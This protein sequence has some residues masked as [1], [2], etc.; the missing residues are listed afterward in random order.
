MMGLLRVTLQQRHVPI[1]NQ[2][3]LVARALFES[4]GPVSAEDIVSSLR[5]RGQH[6]SKAT[7]YR[8]LGLLVEAGFATE[9]DFSQGFK[10][11]ATQAGPALRDHCICTVCGTVTQLRHEEI[12]RLQREIETASGFH[13]LRR[14]FKLYGLCPC[15]ASSAEETGE[16]V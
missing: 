6:V 11:F 14:E 15:C 2:R 9:H 4:V 16:A 10:R 1:T 7:V 3:E 5:S 8:T 13:V 12:Q